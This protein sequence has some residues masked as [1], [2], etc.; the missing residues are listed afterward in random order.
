MWGRKLPSDYVAATS[1]M[2]MAMSRLGPTRRCWG[3][4]CDANCGFVSGESRQVTR[5]AGSGTERQDRLASTCGGD[6]RETCLRW[7]VRNCEA[8]GRISRTVYYTVTEDVVRDMEN[9]S[10]WQYVFVHTATS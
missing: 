6:P 7:A 2:A 3:V 1:G 5:W 10:V 9:T 4:G 8:V